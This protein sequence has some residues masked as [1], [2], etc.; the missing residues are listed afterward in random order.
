MR[1]PT[2]RLLTVS[3]EELVSRQGALLEERASLIQYLKTKVTGEEDWHAVSD[4]ANDLR[5]IDVELN[6]ID[7]LLSTDMLEE[8]EEGDGPEAV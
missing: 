1:T 2:E 6:F 3:A 8:F 4:A 5:E 7:E